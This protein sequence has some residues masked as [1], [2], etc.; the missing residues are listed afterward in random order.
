MAG[1]PKPVIFA[2]NRED[3]VVDRLGN[4]ECIVKKKML[5]VGDFIVSDRIAVERKVS[6]D[7]IQSIV[8]Q[9]LFKQLKSLKENFEKPILII[10]GND[11]YG[12]LHPN[13]VRGALISIAIDA[14]IPI[15]WSKSPEETAGLIYWLAK[16]EQIDEGRKVEILE[17]RRGVSK[18]K[19][20]EFIVA[21]L[22][23]VSAVLA[24][25]LLKKFKSIKSVFNAD[26]KDLQKV[27]GIG[28]EKSKKIVSLI[29]GKYKR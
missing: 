24:K 5:L 9:R 12:R 6:E 20:Q 23:D 16:R 2:D 15:L 18:A 10:E 4:F 21:G 28:K 13:A 1:A 8:D 19:Q 11:L 7:F 14:N 26:E 3:M 17:G 22:P 25:R 29:K 27:E